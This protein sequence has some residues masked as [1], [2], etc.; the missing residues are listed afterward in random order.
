MS[1]AATDI[2]V[3]H[4]LK[5]LKLPMIARQYQSLAREAE[6]HNLSYEAY[7]MAL[8]EQEA[9]SRDQH[10]REARLRKAAFPLRKTLDTL[11]FS[12]FPV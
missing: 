11:T 12:S 7:L 3:G 9:Q 1:N 5:R 10:Q 8:L 6:E 4:L 2:L